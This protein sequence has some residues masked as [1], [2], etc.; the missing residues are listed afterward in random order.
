[1]PYDAEQAVE[2]EQNTGVVMMPITDIVF[3]DDLYPRIDTS[4]FKVQE[5][6]NDIGKMPPIEINQ[7][8]ILI[9]GWHRWTAHKK[10][11]LEA[12]PTI[13][14]V[15]D[16]EVQVLEL[17]IRRNAKHGHQLSLAD[18]R[19]QT[20]RIY[21]MFSFENQKQREAKKVELADMMSVNLR[22]IQGWTERTDKDV[23]EE[24]RKQTF[25][26]WL[27]CHTQDEISK[28]VGYSQK[29][30][31]DLLDKIASFSAERKLSFSAKD[32]DFHQETYELEDA[33]EDTPEDDDERG[34]G[35]IKLTKEQLAN[36][37]HAIDFEAPIYNIWKQQTKTSG[38]SHFGNSEV[39]WVDNLLYLYTQPF[40]VVVDPF[41]GGGSTIDIC[42][43]RL[44]RYWASDRLP[45]VEREKDIRKLDLTEGM[46]SVR[47]KDVGLVYLDPPYWRQ[48][49]NEYSEDQ[50]DL[51]NME[52]ERFND[53]L[54]GIVK[55]FANR[56]AKAK[57]DKPSYIALII[58]PTQWKAPDRQYTD[59]IADMI[60]AVKL[61]IDMRISVPYESQQYNAQMVEWAKENKKVLVLSREIVVWK[62]A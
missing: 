47:W 32:D 15:T 8:R 18:K 7:H 16:S 25:D 20:V 24:L 31:S 35:T 3:R 36:A 43:K 40:D 28:V 6:S 23:K 60:K 19:K 4:A 44:R 5:Y 51:G 34:L 57:R 41:A 30:V 27:S 26:L 38:S 46:P 13:T 62:V 33:P 22:T 29:A 2:T 11:G 21:G 10:L 54:S 42:K 56:M 61:P 14:T 45:I 53:V 17:S 58:Q 52:L 37:D 9:D 49:E 1:M 59:H 48:A 12:I 55:E 50:S 39:R